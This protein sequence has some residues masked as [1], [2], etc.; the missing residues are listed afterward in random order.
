MILVLLLVAIIFVVGLIPYSV[1]M[2]WFIRCPTCG[3]RGTL[4]N[5]RRAVLKANV[6][7]HELTETWL[8]YACRHCGNVRKNMQGTWYDVDHEEWAMVMSDEVFRFQP[9]VE[10]EM[11]PDKKP[12]KKTLRK[13][14]D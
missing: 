5:K 13:N 4:K 1:Y 6:D 14:R 10:H 8:Y 9:R 2:Q 7:G 12:K 3:K 11:K